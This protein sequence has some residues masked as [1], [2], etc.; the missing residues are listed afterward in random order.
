M[1]T[2]QVIKGWDE[3]LLTMKVGGKR[4]L[5][6]PSKLAY[7]KKAVGNESMLSSALILEEI[8]PSLLTLR[9]GHV[10]FLLCGLAPLLPR[11]SIKGGVLAQVMD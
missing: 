1:G 4:M 6:I 3:G 7:G 11:N 9:T 5:V 8:M 10:C 2:G